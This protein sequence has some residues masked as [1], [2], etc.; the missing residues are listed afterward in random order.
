V[1]RLKHVTA[2]FIACI[3]TTSQFVK[4][5]NPVLGET[6]QVKNQ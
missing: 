6:L 4:P 5:F 2:A 3:H 1:E